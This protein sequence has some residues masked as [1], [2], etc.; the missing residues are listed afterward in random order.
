M[1]KTK[2]ALFVEG[3]DFQILG[4]LARKIGDHDVGNRRNFAVVPV[5]G[6][7]PE[8]I[9]NLKA[10]METTRHPDYRGCNSRPRLPL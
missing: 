7:N 4:K 9:K 8:R 1:A 5:E 10:G 3:K 6:F 2:R